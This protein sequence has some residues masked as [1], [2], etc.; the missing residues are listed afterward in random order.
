MQYGKADRGLRYVS[1]QA[2]SGSIR[3]TT[4]GRESRL[5]LRVEVVVACEHVAEIGDGDGLGA[6]IAQEGG[7]RVHLRGRT[8]QRHHSG[9][10]R[11]AKR[12]DNPEAFA[13]LS[14]QGL[15]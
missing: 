9:R 8:M 3:V 7:E 11:L 1:S 12:Q 5:E 6:V 2:A 13:R 15:V 10:R 4:L 14:E